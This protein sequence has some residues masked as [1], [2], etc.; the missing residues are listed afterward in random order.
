MTPGPL[1]R[2]AGAVGL[3]ALTPVALLLL[4]GEIGPI[5]AAQRAV[6]VLV[7]VVV[8]GR[9]TGSWLGSLVDRFED[10][11]RSSGA[12]PGRA[13]HGTTPQPDGST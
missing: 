3:L 9:L 12:E 13:T 8:A 11:G 10:G 1:R 4:S 6:V 7:L 5:A 2:T